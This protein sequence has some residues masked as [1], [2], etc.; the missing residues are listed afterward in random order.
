M[1]G[2]R[3]VLSAASSGG[4]L[5]LILGVLAMTGEYRHRTVG[6]TFLVTPARG[7]V[8]AA[9]LVTYAFVGLAVAV[10]AGALTLAI[11]LP[12]LA[13]EGAHVRLLEDIGLVL[14]GATAETVLYGALGVAVGAL[15]R[16]QATALALSL[17]WV[18]FVESLFVGLLPELGRWLPGGAASA[19]S[20][21]TVRAGDLLPMWAAALVLAG[22]AGGFAAAASRLVVRRDVV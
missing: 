17:L 14:A 5:A 10:A 16:N 18:T 9:K 22:Y 8:V 7:R 12:W 4:I 2:V 19:L 11:A 21:T 1:E 15:L 13:H 3:N 6:E 20:L